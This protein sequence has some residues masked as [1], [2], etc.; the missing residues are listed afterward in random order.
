MAAAKE[1]EVVNN[2]MDV[3]EDSL[4]GARSTASSSKPPTDTLSLHDRVSRFIEGRAALKVNG[5]E[6]QKLVKNKDST[7]K[8]ILNSRINS[9]LCRDLNGGTA[10]SVP[11]KI[12]NFFNN[13]DDRAETCTVRSVFVSKQNLSYSFDPRSL[14]CQS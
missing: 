8:A 13:K 3:E 2:S 6:C 4:E 7:Y 1:G 11:V 12:G 10:G 5:S 14:L 9:Q